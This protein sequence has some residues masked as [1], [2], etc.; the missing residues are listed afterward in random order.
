MQP[1]PLSLMVAE[2]LVAAAVKRTRAQR[3]RR[4]G[5]SAL[6]LRLNIL[7]AVTTGSGP[8]HVAA[9]GVV[10]EASQLPSRHCPLLPRRLLPPLL[11]LLILPQV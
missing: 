4:C 10:S 2:E 9:A 8:W 7:E 6:T 1:S 3:Q 5:E 11:L